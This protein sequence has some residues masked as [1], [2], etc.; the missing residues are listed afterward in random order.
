MRRMPENCAEVV[1]EI[2]DDPFDN[3]PIHDWF[4]LSYASF[5]TIPRLVMQSMP[6]AWQRRM[7]ALLEDLDATFDWRP[8][9]GRYWVRLRLAQGVLLA[10]ARRWPIRSSRLGGSVWLAA[11]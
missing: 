8:A 6:V 1:S 7:V 10:S 5:L 9:R 4:E 11:C 3:T 2:P